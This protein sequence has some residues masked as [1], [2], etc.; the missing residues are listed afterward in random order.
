MSDDSHPLGPIL[1]DFADDVEM[2]ELIQLFVSEMPE[3]ISE[4][5]RAYEDADFESVKRVAHQLKGACAGYGFSMIGDAAAALEST[6]KSTQ[7]DI[8]RISNEFK[9][10]VELCSRAAA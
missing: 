7:D 6:M 8:N 4:M 2:Q 9:Q 5:Q 1:S 3:R 10:L